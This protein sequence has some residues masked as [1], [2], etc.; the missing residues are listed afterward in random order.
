MDAASTSGA[1]PDSPLAEVAIV[2]E[3]G[4][5]RDAEVSGAVPAGG[6]ADHDELDHSGS[7]GWEVVEEGE[8]VADED[9]SSPGVGEEAG[10]RALLLA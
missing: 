8:G 10:E 4:D 5:S 7:E 6:G 3:G 2:D 1:L 9:G